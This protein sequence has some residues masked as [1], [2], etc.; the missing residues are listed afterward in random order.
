MAVEIF[1]IINS[2]VSDTPNTNT[3]SCS[4]TRH[5]G[6]KGKRYSSYSFSTS[7]PD[8]VRSQSYAPAALYPRERTPSTHWIGDWVGLRAGLDKEATGKILCRSRGSNPGR[9]VYSQTLY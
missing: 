1:I 4:A 5:A 3:K 9:S 8:G 6:G 7:T 2:E